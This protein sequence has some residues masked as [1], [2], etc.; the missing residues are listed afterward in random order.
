MPWQYPE[1]MPQLEERFL[2]YIYCGVMKKLFSYWHY[3]SY[4][5]SLLKIISKIILLMSNMIFS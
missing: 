2:T 3:K 4:I 1:Q 5:I